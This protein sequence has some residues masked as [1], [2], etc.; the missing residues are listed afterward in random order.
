MK[1]AVKK[2]VLVL[3]CALGSSAFL[4]SQAQTYVR[5]V[6]PEDF[7]TKAIYAD[8]VLTSIVL[9]RGVSKLTSYPKFN[10]AAYELSQVLADPDKK[11]LQVWVC[12]SASPDGLWEYNV[13]LSK[14]RTDE[15]AAY[16]KEVMNLPDSLIHKERLNED[17]DKL[18]ELVAASDMKHKDQVVN[19]IKTKTWGARKDALQKLDHGKVWTRLVKDFFPSL[20]CVRFAIYCKWDPSK[21]HLSA[22]KEPVTVTDTV[23]VRETVTLRD[24]VT[25]TE[26]VVLRDTVTLK[27]TVVLRDTVTLR[28]TVALP[29]PVVLKETVTPKDTIFVRD[30]VVVVKEKYVVTKEEVYNDYRE[31]SM[32]QP[33]KQIEWLRPNVMAIKTNLISDAMAIPALGL[34]FQIY[35][36][37][38]L[39]VSGSYGFYTI[40]NPAQRDM[41][42]WHVSPEL[43]WWFGK[44]PLQRGS[45]I[46]LHANVSN[47]SLAWRD[48]VAYQNVPG[49]ETWSAGFTYGACA[50]LGKHVGL[51]FVVGVGYGRYYQN[52]GTIGPDGA[53][54]V[55]NEV[56]PQLKEHFGLT[57][58]ALNL[59]YRFSLAGKKK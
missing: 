46:G 8:S 13:K 7:A 4:F 42:L 21:P 54:V 53:F 45:F 44:H 19:I 27:E 20:R 32:T 15:A 56:G 59:V 40:V 41:S 35:K 52:I 18:A 47:Y 49:H 16:L 57:K 31:A 24:T 14:E 6:K 48:G 25:L 50:R 30:T 11:L 10:A 58:L 55:N 33:E 9:P 36:G 12:G 37:L 1:L 5:Y 23:T 51:E 38:S 43:R 3:F 2:L 29:A 22:P 26:T 17:W 34:E 39:D 28:D